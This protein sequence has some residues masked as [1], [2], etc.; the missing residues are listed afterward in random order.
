MP[1]LRVDKMLQN[2]PWMANS[3]RKSG[4]TIAVEAARDTLRAA[5]RKKVTDGNLLDGILEAYKAGWRR[6]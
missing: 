3:V 5:I 6:V 2:I 1:S 4:L